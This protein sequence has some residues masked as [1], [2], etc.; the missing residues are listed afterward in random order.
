MVHAI[1]ILHYYTQISMYTT[2]VSQ[3]VSSHTASRAVQKLMGATFSMQCVTRPF[4]AT[5]YIYL[6][7]RSFSRPQ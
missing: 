5:L 2:A 4:V 1:I 6:P 7:E 3:T